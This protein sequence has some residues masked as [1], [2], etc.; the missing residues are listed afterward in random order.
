MEI[1]FVKH[2]G[3]LVKITDI[4]SKRGVTLW[5]IELYELLHQ[6]KQ[7]TNI[8]ISHPLTWAQFI[9]NGAFYIN[10]IPFTDKFL[11]INKSLTRITLDRLSISSL[12]EM[13][14]KLFQYFAKITVCNRTEIIHID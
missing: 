14:T 6:I 1:F 2:N 7:Y 4:A 5:Q 3:V 12:L 9:K 11:L 13:E 8:N 10:K